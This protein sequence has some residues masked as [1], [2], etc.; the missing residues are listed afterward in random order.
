[1]TKKNC[2]IWLNPQ[3]PLFRN[4]DLCTIFILLFLWPKLY[5]KLLARA[6][7]RG[8]LLVLFGMVYLEVM[9]FWMI[10][11]RPSLSIGGLSV[12][13]DGLED[14]QC[15]WVEEKMGN[16][17]LY[18]PNL[19]NRGQREW[20]TLRLVPLWAK[21]VWSSS[22]WRFWWEEEGSSS[23]TWTTHPLQKL[24]LL[25]WGRMLSL[26]RELS[27]L[28]SRQVPGNISAAFSSLRRDPSECIW[29]I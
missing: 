14:N 1:M 17:P 8:F 28:L 16:Y 20:N 26:R 15:E 23:S 6:T 2:M 25:I 3:V 9:K 5:M 12:L 24:V 19:H 10:N 18:V 11:C 13:C 22:K 7:A 21:L 4:S 29:S 27:M